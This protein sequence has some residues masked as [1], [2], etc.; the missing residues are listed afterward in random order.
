MPAD[1]VEWWNVER[2]VAAAAALA[3]VVGI[4]AAVFAW[5]QAKHARVS[6]EFAEVQAVAAME[7]ARY[8]SRALELEERKDRDSRAPRF[9]VKYSAS[10][11]QRE[12]ALTLDGPD[13]LAEL[14]VRLVGTALGRRPPVT[15]ADGA[16]SCA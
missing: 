5:R 9:S 8:M 11:N 13:C 6:A 2:V 15:F 3:A 7:Q 10:E 4:G 1:L 16:E 12:A 14:D